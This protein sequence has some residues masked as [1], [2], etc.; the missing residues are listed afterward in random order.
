M[1]STALD[2]NGT[3]QPQAKNCSSVSQRES[4]RK[5]PPE[6]KKPI[7]APSCGNM[8]Y[9]ARLPGGAFSVASRIAPPHSPPSPRPWPNRHSASS[10]GAATPI[11]WIG[12]QRADRHRRDAHRQ[13]RR[14]QRRLAADAVAE[15]PEQRRA[16]RAG[17]EGD[18][19]GGE[20]GQRRGRRIG[21]RG[22]T[23]S[24][25]PAPRRWRRCR[26]RRTRWPCPSGWRRGSAAALLTDRVG[27]V[28]T[29]STTLMRRASARRHRRGRRA[30]PPAARR[31]R[32][33]RATSR[34]RAGSTRR[35]TS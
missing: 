1:T 28:P 14:D 20:R 15:V 30:A 5:I 19:E 2:R 24:G 16:D 7:G 26:S 33:R 32:D 22:R 8:P 18:G 12:R 11:G 6:Q 17:Q 10:S 9:Q 3:R 21:R 4:S 29:G 13:Q 27:S 31:A 25:R 34:R 23:A 35:A